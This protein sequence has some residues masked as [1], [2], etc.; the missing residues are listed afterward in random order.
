MTIVDPA[1]TTSSSLF[2]HRS[3]SPTPRS[4]L[5]LCL[6]WQS[7]CYF[8]HHYV[9]YVHKSPCRGRLAFFPDLYREKGN[10]ENS[11]LKHAILSVASMALFN[12]ARVGQLYVNARRHY[13]SAMRFL[14]R[15]LEDCEVVGSDEVFAAVLF[16]GVFTV[17]FFFLLGRI[18][19][20]AK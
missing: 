9:F 14:S 7:I 1:S 12:T 13:G 17:F 3:S 19:V 16:L 15:A 18:R 6:D 10:E 8:A 20:L 11:Y 5:S 2:T 4:K